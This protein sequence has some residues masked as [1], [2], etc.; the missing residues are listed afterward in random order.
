MSDLLAAALLAIGTAFLLIASIGIIRMP[1]LFTRMQAATKAATLGIGC[2]LLAAAFSLG[3][4][5]VAIRAL[6]TIGFFLL[7]APVAAHMIGRAAYIVRVPLWEGTLA[8][9]LRG[10]Y[11]PGTHALLSQPR[12]PASRA[13]PERA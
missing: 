10:H 1:D 9:E 5:G 6:L 2:V 13:G 4:L 3:D 11:E 12:S 7:T 8:D